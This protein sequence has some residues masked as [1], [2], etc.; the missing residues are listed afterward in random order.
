MNYSQETL[1]DI[2]KQSVAQ[3]IDEQPLILTKKLDVNERTVAAEISRILSPRFADFDVNCEYNRMTAGNGEP[4]PKRL[5]LDEPILEAELIYPDI[6]IHHQKDNKHN[7]LV[8]EIKMQWKNNRKDFDF[9]K[10]SAFTT[11]LHYQY[12]LYLELS[13]TGISD[14]RWFSNGNEIQA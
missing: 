13:E 5:I 8:I 11:Q 10:L 4:I 3:L 14:G 2:V 9:K 6:I 1:S 7:L 12:G